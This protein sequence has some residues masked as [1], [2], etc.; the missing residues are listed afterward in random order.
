MTVTVTVLVI[1]IVVGVVALS[2]IV[3]TAATVLNSDGSP[4]KQIVL[5]NKLCTE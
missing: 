4:E 2:A 5:I 1:V 3:A